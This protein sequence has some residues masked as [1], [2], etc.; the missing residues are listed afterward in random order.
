MQGW[1]GRGTHLSV[2]VEMQRDLRHLPNKGKHSRVRAQEKRAALTLQATRPPTRAL[3]CRSSRC[4]VRVPKSGSDRVQLIFSR[5]APAVKRWKMGQTGTCERE[6][7]AERHS[8]AYLGGAQP[9]SLDCLVGDR[10]GSIPAS[11]AAQGTSIVKLQRRQFGVCRDTQAR[12]Q[13]TK[14]CGN[15]STLQVSGH[16][17]S[18]S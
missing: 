9:W 8:R 4:M 2:S 5:V 14:V 7:E 17:A 18:P 16:P 12:R 3:E 1:R 6:R 13:S 11:A 10:A 15:A